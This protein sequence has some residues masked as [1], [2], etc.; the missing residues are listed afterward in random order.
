MAGTF[1]RARSSRRGHQHC[2]E[3]ARWLGPGSFVHRDGGPIPVGEPFQV[4]EL[5]TSVGEFKVKDKV[6]EQFEPGAYT[7]T[8]L[9]DKIYPHSYV[10]YGKV[11]V[12]SPIPY[13]LTDLHGILV[14][15]MGK[16]EFIAAVGKTQT[17]EMD[18]CAVGIVGS[19]ARWLGSMR[20]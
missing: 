19:I 5:T 7:G 3:R 14:N 17:G 9:I 12:D 20:R 1:H 10:W 18:Y 16:D 4:G 13:L 8:F 2:R 6:L 11:T 15:E